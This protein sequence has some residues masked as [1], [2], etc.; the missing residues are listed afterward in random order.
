[1]GDRYD[2]LELC[3]KVASA[4]GTAKGVEMDLVSSLADS[5]GVDRDRFRTMTDKIVPVSIHET[6]DVNKLLGIDPEWSVDQKKKHLRQENRKW[7]AL[8]THAD[9]DKKEQARQMQ[10]L[11]AR[12]MALLEKTDEES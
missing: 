9:Q 1:M 8:A 7:R 10:E 4:D 6:E 11:I 12:E 2:I 5:L 3:L